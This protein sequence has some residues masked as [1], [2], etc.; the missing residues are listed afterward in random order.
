M[1]AI[2]FI[3]EKLNQSIGLT[4]FVRD[5]DE[6]YKSEI[7]GIIEE[8]REM[9]KQQIIDAFKEGYDA[10]WYQTDLGAEEYYNETSNK[11]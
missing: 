11:G 6:D 8:S 9:E 4:K 7:L 1:T 5:C 3:I 10:G 2:E